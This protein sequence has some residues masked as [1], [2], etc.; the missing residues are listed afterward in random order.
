[1]SKPG[2]EERIDRE[3]AREEQ[4]DDLDAGDDE[5]RETIRV[6]FCRIIIAVDQSDD[7]RGKQHV[8]DGFPKY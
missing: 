1:M 6:L 5:E 8:D 7:F 2:K 4:Q 3:R